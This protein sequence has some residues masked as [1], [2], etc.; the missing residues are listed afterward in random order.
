MIN[1]APVS[2]EYALKASEFV[3]YFPINSANEVLEYTK[4]PNIVTSMASLL[5]LL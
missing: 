2:D 5:V 1:M 3:K 4:M